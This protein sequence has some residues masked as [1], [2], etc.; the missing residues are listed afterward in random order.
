MVDLLRLRNWHLRGQLDPV[1][2]EPVKEGLAFRL[3]AA[4][5]EEGLLAALEEVLAELERTGEYDHMLRR[6]LG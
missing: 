2:V 6:Y 5:A 1:E 3:A 4:P